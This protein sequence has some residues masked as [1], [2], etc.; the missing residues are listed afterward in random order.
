MTN[1]LIMDLISKETMLLLR[2]ALEN[3]IIGIF[4]EDGNGKFGRNDLALYLKIKDFYVDIG[5]D[6]DDVITSQLT[7][8]LEDFDQKLGLIFTDQ[9]A[10]LSIK[11]L[12]VLDHIDPSA[13]KWPD[14]EEYQPK[15]GFLLDLDINKLD[16]L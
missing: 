5:I 6:E 1:A 12:F 3:K 2:R 4:G 16:V 10:L 9:N 11:N 13:I 15:N 8:I 7:I 14:N